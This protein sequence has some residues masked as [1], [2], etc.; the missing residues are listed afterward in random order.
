MTEPAARVLAAAFDGSQAGDPGVLDTLEGMLD[1]LLQR[2]PYLAA[3]V[4]VYAL[5]H[6]TGVAVRRL[7]RRVASRR[8]NRNRNLGLVF[9]RLAQGLIW[10]VGLLVA[11]VIAIPRFTPGQLIQL[12]GLSGVA[13]GFAFRDILQ[14]FLAGILILLTEPFRIDDQIVFGEYEGT[15]EDI[16]TRATY[17]R[18][19]DGRRIVIPNAELYT[20]PVTVNTAFPAR[21]LEYDIGIGYSDD[22]E[23]AKAIVLDVLAASPTVLPDPA[24]QVLVV[25]LA[26]SAVNLRVLWWVT[27]PRRLETLAARDEVLHAVKA[28]LLQAG[29][30]LPFPTRTVLLQDQRRVDPA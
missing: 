13:I 26:E 18:T 8:R 15:V 17:L 23:S 10:L 2:L 29:I 1:S 27:P 30:D 5:F 21:R 11:A 24:P 22:L 16:Q 19:Y 3:A 12:L 25:D 20:R 4:V 28:A 6:F 9:G 14:N 7:V